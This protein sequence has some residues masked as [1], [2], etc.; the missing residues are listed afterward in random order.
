MLV[1]NTKQLKIELNKLSN[2]IEKYEE[3]KINLFL[4]LNNS[5]IDWKD[6]DSLKFSDKIYLEKQET[7]LF[8]DS[9]KEKKD[10]YLY[11]YYQYNSIG[12]Y[13]RYETTNN[14]NMIN[15]ISDNVDICDSIIS[16]FN[17]ITEKKECKEQYNLI[18]ERNKIINVKNN[19]LYIRKRYQDV[20]KLITEIETNIKNKINN[21][22]KIKINDFEMNN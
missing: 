13:I 2:L 19:L 22:D 12:N 9:I 6:N 18:N 1:V 15:K 3:T 16:Q 11:M 20:Q 7:D 14:I 21:L 4:N 8:I 5:C 10:I 17:V